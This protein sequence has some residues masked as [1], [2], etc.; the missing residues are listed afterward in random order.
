MIEFEKKEGSEILPE[1][2][3]ITPFSENDVIIFFEEYFKK[4][5]D[6]YNIYKKNKF[7]NPTKDVLDDL[8]VKL[9]SFLK[10]QNKEDGEILTLIFKNIECNFKI[11]KKM[12]LIPDNEKNQTFL[13]SFII[14]KFFS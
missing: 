4:S 12:N 1:G 5:V 6:T 14:S 7:N 13:L 8:N 3:K 2:K 11:L 10:D 9:E